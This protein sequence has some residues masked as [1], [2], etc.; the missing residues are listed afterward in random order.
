ML[1]L[2]IL[3]MALVLCRF[4]LS[5]Q[6]TFP[7]P[8][9]PDSLTTPEARTAYLALHFWEKVDFTDVSVLDS[10]KPALDFIYLLSNTEP[11]VSAA[12]LS[13]MLVRSSR[14]DSALGKLI[15]WF[16]HFL[17]DAKSPLFNDG[18]YA[19]FL[20]AAM[21]SD[22]PSEIKDVL[23]LQLEVVER[24]QTGSKAEDFVFADK[25]GREYHIFNVDAPYI[26][27]MF[28]NPDCSI[29]REVQEEMSGME[30]LDKLQKEGKLKVVAIFPGTDYELWRAH[31]Y[32]DS[33]QAG[34]D[35]SG[36]IKEER[37]YEIQ[38]YPCFYLLD[39]EKNV[40]IKEAEWGKLKRLICKIWAD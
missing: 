34:Y 24:N 29:C 12:A 33:W 4:T 31:K 18:M 17:H 22:A 35:L 7:Y 6:A 30:L 10:S 5:G 19:D 2:K 28:T 13:A 16:S 23:G 39:S 32:P 1:R 20:K 26:L 11:S 36:S 3:L 27:L 37:L 9:V 21:V 15:Y 25:E 40:L 14:H 8:D 38:Y